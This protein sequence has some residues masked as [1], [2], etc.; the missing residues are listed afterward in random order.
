MLLGRAALACKWR[1]L[2]QRRGARVSLHGGVPFLLYYAH[3]GKHAYDIKVL[4]PLRLDYGPWDMRAHSCVS[5]VRNRRS[6]NRC[7]MILD[8]QECPI[9]LPCPN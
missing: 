3:T 5:S 8:S 1:V 2:S 9:P 4:V 7:R 6:D